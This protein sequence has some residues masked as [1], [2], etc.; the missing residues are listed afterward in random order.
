MLF[1]YFILIKIGPAGSV[2]CL[3]ASNTIWRCD[4]RTILSV[5]AIGGIEAP[6]GRADWKVHS[7]S[8]PAMVAVTVFDFGGGGGAAGEFVIEGE[9]E[10][11]MGAE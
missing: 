8:S 6:A 10:G 11:M 2:G 7:S 1:E 5:G 9:E 4:A 3:F